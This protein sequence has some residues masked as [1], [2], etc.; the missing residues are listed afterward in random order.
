M[1]KRFDHNRGRLLLL[2]FIF[3]LL[4]G[5]IVL[6]YSHHDKKKD[7][8]SQRNSYEQNIRDIWYKQISQLLSNGDFTNARLAA[9][10]VLHS[11]PEDIFAR[12]VLV[13]IAA[14]EKN[15]PA[16]IKLCR[17]IL[18]TNPED[19]FTRNNLAVLLAADAPAEAVREITI[20][21]QLLP[22]NPVIIYNY[23][24]INNPQQN[25]KLP[26]PSVQFPDL[27]TIEAAPA[28]V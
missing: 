18:H 23:E 6:V 17:E 19:A 3:I 1:K 5:M 14:I 7:L 28:G 13:R 9:N 24:R 26:L 15:H 8:S 16:A 11:L 20:A 2:I 4:A 10:K 25:G 22:D 12:R 21:K 27:L